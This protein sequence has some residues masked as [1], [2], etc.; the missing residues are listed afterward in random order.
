MSWKRGSEYSQ[1][2]RDMVIETPGSV[3]EVAKR[4]GVSPA[5][6][7]RVV[8]RLR[9][10]GGRTT[11]PRGGQRKPILAGR[12]DV[13]RARLVELPDTTLTEL[14]R[15]LMDTHGI[16]ISIG[17][18]WGS[19]RRMGFGTRTSRRPEDGARPTASE[20]F[21]ATIAAPS[22]RPFVD[23]PVTYGAELPS[24]LRELARLAMQPSAEEFREPV[25]SI[26]TEGQRRGPG[27][28]VRGVSLQPR[29][30]QNE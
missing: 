13:L 28:Q 2:L 11:K 25:T 20:G 8:T 24:S 15:W 19:L 3:R 10:T 26:L 18:L 5:Y 27:E 1:D 17:A 4:F 29:S 30:I 21:V 12:E 14:Q 9:L 16:K 22:K 23:T 6:V 7:S